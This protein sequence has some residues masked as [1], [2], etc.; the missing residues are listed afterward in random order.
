MLQAREE[1]KQRQQEEDLRR[2]QEKEAERQKA[3]EVEAVLEQARKEREKAEEEEYNKWK[4]LISVEGAGTQDD[5]P[6]IDAFVE[7]VE[8][9]KVVA[10]TDL[11]SQFGLSQQA[12][13]QRVQEL[14]ASGRL[15]GVIDDRGK[16]VSI[17]REEMEKITKF[18]RQR[19]RV[20]IAEL[21]D[22]SAKLIAMQEVV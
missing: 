9:A 1:E 15:S 10:L 17:T 21:V 4:H 13:I 12:T 8:K 2:E 18:I 5:A 16:F 3:A 11:A 20:S 22:A 14:E 7:Y 6:T 19:G